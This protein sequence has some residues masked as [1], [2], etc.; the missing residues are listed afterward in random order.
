MLKY[1]CAQKQITT[2]LKNENIFK[3]LL[4]WFKIL[5]SLYYVSNI[6]IPFDWNKF[7]NH[8]KKMIIIKSQMGV[9]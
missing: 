7:V 2:Y 6:V 5:W 4:K 3:K 8:V 9:F 1:I